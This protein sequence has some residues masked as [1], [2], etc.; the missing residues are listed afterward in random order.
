MNDAASSPGLNSPTYGDHGSSVPKDLKD[1]AT[2]KKNQVVSNAADIVKNPH[3][4]LFVLAG[5]AGITILSF[6]SLVYAIVLGKR[7]RD[8]T[9]SRSV[10]TTTRPY[11]PTGSIENEETSTDASTSS[12]TSSSTIE[13]TST[14]ARRTT[15]TTT[16]ETTSASST[17]T[18]ELPSAYFDESTGITYY[19]DPISGNYYFWD[20]DEEAYVWYE[21]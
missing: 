3:M 14:N 17:A 18:A 5:W 4:R 7:L 13:A 16:E 12:T 21:G 10:T 1:A 19:L 15:T 11:W 6:S 8:L 9:E 20:A 2:S